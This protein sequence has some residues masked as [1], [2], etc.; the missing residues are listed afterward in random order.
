MNDVFTATARLNAPPAKVFQALTDSEALRTWLSEHAEVSLA[1]GVYEFWGRYTPQG[2]RG[3]QKL[4]TAKPG[5]LLRFEWTLDGKASTVEIRL[6]SDGDGT[7]VAQTQDRLPTLDEMM[8]NTGSRDGLHTMHTFW[9]LA[10][11]QLGEYVE[12][13]ELTPRVD[14]SSER[15][16]EIRVQVTV[17]GTPEA[18]FESLTDPARIEGWFGWP[19]EVEP[20]VGGK[21]TLGAEG[22]I[23]QFEPGKLL[24]YGDSEMITCWELEGSD[25]H[26]R[27]TFVQTGF[28][29]DEKDNAAQH[30]AGWLKGIAELKRMHELGAD[31]KP[32]TESHLPGESGE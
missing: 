7:K 10:L 4:L 31:W 2:E 8:S 11:E 6:E 22:R 18:V 24:V 28:T 9:S 5:E 21:M 20:R 23:S 26:T 25:G 12:G 15:A 17:A 14:F 30:E 16:N 19:A 3:R 1:D 27:L 32:L 13:R 29:E